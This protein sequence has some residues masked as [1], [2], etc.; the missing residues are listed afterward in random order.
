M[1]L[2][3]PRREF[4]V[5]YNYYDTLER[6]GYNIYYGAKGDNGN[7]IMTVSNA[8][9]SE[10]LTTS[11][12]QAVA[13]TATKYIDVDF[14]I[15]FNIPKNI[16]GKA[17]A[18]IPLGMEALSATQYDFEYY[19]IV[20]AIHVSTGATETILATGTT[21]TINHSGIVGIATGGIRYTAAT[22]MC[23]PDITTLKHFAI[24]EKLRFTVEG[25]FK[26]LE[27]G[28][29]NAIT[30]LAHDPANR[31]SETSVTIP[32][33]NSGKVFANE[34]FGG[35]TVTHQRTQMSFHVPFILDI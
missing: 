24:G 21:R 13:T 29:Q 26:C 10:D 20:K 15:T 9:Y 32:T 18:I 16:K 7:H 31:N 25:W 35:G 3:P 2:F 28:P 33:D 6:I 19:A 27:A 8:V 4:Q 17:I 30:T 1:P 14:D 11:T 23:I 34:V 5:N 12:T 22:L